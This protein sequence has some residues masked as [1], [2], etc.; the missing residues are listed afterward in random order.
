MET[1]PVPYATTLNQVY[2]DNFRE[3]KPRWDNLIKRY[4]YLYGRRPELVA[5]SPG[6]VNIIGEHI[7]Y[8]LYDVLPMAI[9]PDVLVAISTR[10]PPPHAHGEG[11]LMKVANTI[12]DKYPTREF[13]VSPEGNVYIDGTKHEWT[14]YFKAGLDGSIQLLRKKNPE[15]LPKS[16][17]V[18]LDGSVPAGGGLSSSAAFVCSTALAI[19]KAHG[20]EVTKKD[21][22]ELCIVSERRVGVNSGG[23]DQAASIFSLR[24]TAL[25]TSFVPSIHTEHVKFP[26]TDP[27]MVFLI[28]Q[29]L[30]TSDKQVTGPVCYNLRVVE[31]TL[32]A[33]VLAKIFNLTLEPDSSSLGLS[34]RGF[35]L[36]LEALD[37][38]FAKLELPDQLEKLISIVKDK[39]PSEEGYT[40]EDISKLLG[41]SIADIESQYMT[42]F[43]IRATH[44]QLRKRALH[45]YSEALRV[46]KFKDLLV[47]PLTPGDKAASVNRLTE[48][49]TL[50]NETQISCRDVYECSCPELDE[51]CQ[52]AR[53]AGSA[54]SRVT[55]A[56]WGGASVHLVPGDRVRDVIAAWKSGYYGKKFPD[57]SPDKLREAIVVSKPSPGSFV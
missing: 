41:I 16:M 25:Y 49:G 18:L 15:F 50:M 9:T 8:C 57:L 40:R 10:P 46:I 30:I 21:L 51:L 14:N 4:T 13:L 52:I 27:E 32:A 48:L 56:G 39:L 36:A 17:E 35:H 5:R 19:M 29:S 37:S 2:P 55:G 54:G 22:F 6:R 20:A 23:M 7:D 43:P 33:V 53:R 42:K 31:V 45:V 47:Q 26:V 12:P 11:V 34:L 3:V 44:F 28:A 24:G 1:D 38:S